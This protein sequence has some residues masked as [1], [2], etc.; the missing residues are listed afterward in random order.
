MTVTA[1]GSVLFIHSKILIDCCTAAWQK[2]MSTL[3]HV[4]MNG[5]QQQ[6][7]QNHKYTKL[8]TF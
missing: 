3:L 7:Q 8:H 4:W 2:G 5:K 1:G 6:Q